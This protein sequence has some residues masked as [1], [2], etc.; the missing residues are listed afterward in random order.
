VAR[1]QQQYDLTTKE[2]MTVAEL[3]AIVQAEAERQGIHC[4]LQVYPCP[5]YG[6]DAQAMTA[7]KNIVAFTASIQPAG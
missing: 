4:I 3:T 2:L 6:W 7:P 1:L 5:G